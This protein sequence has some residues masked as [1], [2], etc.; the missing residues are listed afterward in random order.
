MDKS[1]PVRKYFFPRPNGE[2][3]GQDQLELEKP[4]ICSYCR[5]NYT[6]YKNGRYYKTCDTCLVKKRQYEENKTKSK[7]EEAR[8]ELELNK[9]SEED[10]TN[11]AICNKC[12]KNPATVTQSRIYKTCLDCRNKLKRNFDQPYEEEELN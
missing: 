4:I 1:F 12:F 9:K 5:K 10:N 7:D 3:K 11:I 8:K 6:S 2:L